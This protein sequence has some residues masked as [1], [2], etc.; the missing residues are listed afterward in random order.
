[1]GATLIMVEWVE[2]VRSLKGEGEGE[3]QREKNRETSSFSLRTLRFLL[4]SFHFLL[5]VGIPA[6]AGIQ[7]TALGSR[8]D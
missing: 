4:R 7:T 8:L 1:M 6:E 5:F 3:S 2:E